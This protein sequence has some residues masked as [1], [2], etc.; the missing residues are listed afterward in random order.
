[1]TIGGNY[2]MEKIKKIG[3][4]HPYKKLMKLKKVNLLDIEKSGNEFEYTY[5]VFATSFFKEH[6]FKL[7]FKSKLPHFV[8]R[9]IQK[10]MLCQ[11]V[12]FEDLKKGKKKDIKI[13]TMLY[14]DLSEKDIARFGKNIQ[15]WTIHFENAVIKQGAFEKEYD[16]IYGPPDLTGTGYLSEY[17]SEKEW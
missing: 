13:G 17:D 10:M 16:K 8:W 11:G 7:V 9:E 2:R 12:Y 1:M 15:E 14:L 3:I 5:G 6:Y 4:K